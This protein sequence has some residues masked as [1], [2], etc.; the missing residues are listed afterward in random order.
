MA[1]R[2]VLV[3]LAVCAIGVYGLGCLDDN[4]NPIDWSVMMKVPKIDGNSNPTVVA[5]LAY[6]Y[7]DPNTTY[8]M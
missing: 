1:M 2:S 7:T 5:G 8:E 3:T 4:G 6:L